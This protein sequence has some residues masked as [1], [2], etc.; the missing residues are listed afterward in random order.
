MQLTR[1]DLLVKNLKRARKAL[2]KEALMVESANYAFF[3]Q[4]FSLPSEY[5]MFVD[6]FKK[7]GG[8]WI[9]KVILK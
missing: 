7:S 5:N 9:M 6:E 3:P 2:D 4:T 1:K 8:V